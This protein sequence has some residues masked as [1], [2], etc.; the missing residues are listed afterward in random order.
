[1][2]LQGFR[3]HGL[4]L[5]PFFLTSSSCHPKIFIKEFGDFLNYRLLASSVE[6]NF[7]TIPSRLQ[8]REKRY[9]WAAIGFYKEHIQQR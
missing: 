4:Y 1:M 3:G 7:P 9:D 5:K 2:R 8:E 6:K